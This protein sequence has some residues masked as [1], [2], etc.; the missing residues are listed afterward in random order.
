MFIIIEK[1]VMILI[2]FDSI[3][4]FVRSKF[5]KGKRLKPKFLPYLIEVRAS[6]RNKCQRLIR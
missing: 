3:Q 4:S 5:M 1:L 2:D 6:T